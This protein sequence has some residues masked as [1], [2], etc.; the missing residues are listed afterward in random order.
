MMSKKS[1]IFNGIIDYARDK[2]RNA[3]PAQ[4]P[5]IRA[6]LEERYGSVGNGI[7]YGLSRF[8]VAI[9]TIF[10]AFIAAILNLAR[11]S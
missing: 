6:T 1:H 5:Q 9:G 7:I 11:K 2:H 3:K 10:A 4:G 8:L